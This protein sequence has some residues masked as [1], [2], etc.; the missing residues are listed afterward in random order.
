MVFSCQGAELLVLVREGTPRI[1]P[2]GTP[3]YSRSGITGRVF[4]L[5]VNLFS[6]VTTIEIEII[7]EILLVVI[8]AQEDRFILALLLFMLLPISHKPDL[9]LPGRKF[10]RL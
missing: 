9:L 10:L 4:L 5:V 7:M 3:S 2:G 1:I 6:G 8:N